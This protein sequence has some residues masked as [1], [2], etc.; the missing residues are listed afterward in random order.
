MAVMLDGPR[1]PAKSRM[2]EQLVV[3]LHGYGTNGNDLIAIGKQWQALLP[4][5]AFAAPN[6]PEPCGQIPG[7]RQ[8]FRLTMRDP[9]ERWAGVNKAAPFLDTFLDAELDRH[10]LDGSKLAL[11]GFS[12]GTMLAL[13]AGL[14]RARTPAAILGYS[15]ELVIPEQQDQA[16]PS[17]PAGK[18]PPIL[19]I[20]GSQDDVIPAEA[21]FLSAGELARAGIACQWHLSSGLGHGIDGEGLLHGGL[22]LAKC[23]GLKQGP[24]ANARL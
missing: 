3:F 7:G 6:A 15:G 10:G 1:L 23:F 11:V 20:H 2:P 19:L 8:W 12:Q 22:F 24:R 13:H 5:A 18:F 16:I 21:L 4:G 9:G 14:R 17:N